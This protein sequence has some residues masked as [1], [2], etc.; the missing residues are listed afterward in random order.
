MLL[1]W[2][3]NANKSELKREQMHTYQIANSIL[4]NYKNEKLSDDRVEF[5]KRQA[6]EQLDEIAQNKKLYKRFLEKIDVSE[7]IDSTILWM[8]IMSNETLC[9][10]YIDECRKT[11]REIIPVSDLAD[12][13][14]YFIYLKKIKGI[15][16]DGFE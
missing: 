8:L 16:S 14:L 10:E 12:L 4:E 5:L 1:F 13:L 3:T 11:F 2:S 6:K 15:E 9:E 7:K